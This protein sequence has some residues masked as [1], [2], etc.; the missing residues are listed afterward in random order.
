MDKNKWYFQT[1][2]LVASFLLIGPF[3]LPLVWANPR[4][5]VKAKTAITICVI[6]LTLLLG[7]L[8]AYALKLLGTSYREILLEEGR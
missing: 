5:S 2:T 3:M 6:I 8:F 7:I 1:W 4:F